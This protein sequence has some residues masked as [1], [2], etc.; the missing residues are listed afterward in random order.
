M[1]GCRLPEVDASFRMK[2]GR[3]RRMAF[4]ENTRHASPSSLRTRTRFCRH[5]HFY[6]RRQSLA[7]ERGPHDGLD[8]GKN[9]FFTG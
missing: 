3:T 6:F 1:A 4:W 2:G 5:S 7:P 9:V 8:Q